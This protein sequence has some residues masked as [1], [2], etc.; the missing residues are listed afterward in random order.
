MIETFKPGMRYKSFQ[1]KGDSKE[2]VFG[3]TY[4]ALRRVE[5]TVEF[6]GDG[7]EESVWWTVKTGEDGDVETEYV[8]KLLSGFVP[9]NLYA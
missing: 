3:R 2:R 5:D 6:L 1:L 7:Y 9:M 8:Q 4:I